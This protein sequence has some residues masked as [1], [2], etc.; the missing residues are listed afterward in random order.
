VDQ[1]NISVTS[2]AVSGLSTNTL[3]YWRVN[4]SSSTATSSYSN[5]WSFT[6]ITTGTLSAPTLSSPTD[7]STGVSTSP[8]L[9]WNTVSGA[10]TYS[11][12]VSTNTGFSPLVVDQSNIAG[13]FYAVSGLSASTLY[14]W[15][16]N[17]SSATVTSAYGGPWS[18]TTKSASLTLPTATTSGASAFAT[19]S[20][21]VSGSVNP[22]GSTCTAWFDWGT[23]SALS[24]YTSTASQSIGS[25]SSDV[26]VSAN[27]SGL[28]SNTRYYYRVAGQNGAGTQKGS[29]SNF[30]TLP[31]APTLIIP[32][33]TSA[34]QSASLS[35]A[36]SSGTGVTYH[37]QVAL[38]S[39]FSSPLLVN[40][41]TLTSASRLVSSLAENCTYYWRARAKN[42]SGYG[43]W[44]STYYFSTITSKTVYSPGVSFPSNPTLATDYRLVS[45]PGMGSISVSQLVTGTQTSDWRMFK[46]NGGSVPNNLTE[47]SSSST[48][49]IGEGYWLL[50]KGT[51]SFSRLVTPVPL[52]S[53]GTYTMSVRT[54]WN[55]I[56]NPF[57]VPVAWSTVQQDNGIAASLWTYSGTSSFQTS[58]TLDPFKGYY[59]YC[60][61]STLRIRYPFPSLKLTEFTPPTIDWKLQLVLETQNT[62][63]ECNYVGIAPSARMDRDDLDQPKP[64]LIFDQPYL[65]VIPASQDA[66]A[67]LL[68][69]DFRPA[70]GEGQVWNFV[71]SN[72][73]LSRCKL[74]ILGVDNVPAEYAV[75]LIDEH[76]TLPIDLRLNNEISFQMHSD[77]MIFHVIVGGKQYVEEQ[78]SKYIPEVFE[79]SQNYPNPFNP[80]TSIT[81]KIHRTASVRVDVFS[82]L[83][84]HVETLAE[85]NRMPGIY[86]VVWNATGS[87]DKPASSGIYF[88][89]LIVD[90]KPVQTKKMTLLK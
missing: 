89:R 75:S 17:A 86:T 36:W 32:S 13:T 60:N 62:S 48:T 82:V 56:G 90:G 27:L 43:A 14:Y 11:L 38:N 69:S 49:N 78:A 71:V 12:Q 2:Y 66:K 87:G 42:A 18:F 23:N 79:L 81:Y 4:A 41:T 30:L 31:D 64:P 16:V 19:S 10:S 46:E 24:S 76:N 45:F 52:T 54:G 8:T 6:T 59:V 39:S 47:L 50:S 3:Y 28:T 53:D 85:G 37:A 51:F 55:L 29:I 57:D 74:R 44:S 40:D 65:S 72:P 83:G 9:S 5:T 25:G 73:R 61:S 68:S 26:T 84:Q 70:I 21:T 63:D 58:A 88:C 35:L 33:N 77:K 7:G 80:S 15:R 67:Q 34:N 1:S 20:A 22:N